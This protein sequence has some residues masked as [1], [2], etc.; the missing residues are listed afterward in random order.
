[1]SRQ[2]PTPGRL[3][4]AGRSGGDYA[5]ILSGVSQNVIGI[6]VAAI[7]MLIVQILMTR[8]LGP[9]GFGVV[10]VLTQAAWVAS[11]GTRAGMDMAIL[12]DVAVEAGVGGWDRMRRPAARAAGI[13]A[14]VSAGVGA[15][16]VAAG[17]TVLGA[18][19]ISPATYP[20]AL[21]A[22]AL[23]LPFLALTNVW[24]A[25]TRG[26]KIMRY[27][28]YVFWAGQNIMWI[29]LTVVLWQISTTATASILAYS[30]SWVWAAVAAAFVWRKQSR[31][32]GAAPAD[33]GSLPKLFKYAGPRAPAALFAQLLFWTDLFVVTRYVSDSEVGVYSVALRAGQVIIVFLASVNL[34]FGPYVADLHNRGHRAR[35]DDLYKTLTRWIV[36][37][38]LPVFMLMAIAPDAVLNIFGPDFSGGRV[39]LLILMG[40]QFTNMVTGSAGFILVMVGRTGWDLAVYAASLAL[41]LGLAFLLSPRYGIE[42]AATASAL[43]FACSNGARL[44]LVRRFV[45]IQ[46]YDSRYGRLVLPT[47]AGTAVMWLVHALTAGG[48]VVDLVATGVG[49][50]LAYALVYGAVGLT[51]AERKGAAGLVARLRSS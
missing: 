23:G 18:F 7:A 19:S 29:V 25:A 1:M 16:V 4:G 21:P 50:G 12:R 26:L 32:W 8:T 44:F 9:V 24:L 15:V 41:V 47:L 37:A 40:G 27:T 33:A 31:H 20:W 36:A 28:L 46:P 3:P 14:L 11:F 13:A 48:D 22:A 30:L 34:M 6:V 35:L 2:A 17:D 38:T 5:T 39:A 10:T 51:P 49:G 43:T 42:G 45:G